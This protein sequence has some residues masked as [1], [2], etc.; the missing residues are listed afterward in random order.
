MAWG[1]RLA[2]AC[3]STEVGFWAF[4]QS[5]CKG[6]APPH[7]LLQWKK[8]FKRNDARPPNLHGTV[9]MPNDYPRVRAAREGSVVDLI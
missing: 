7:V 3:N 5:S 1:W 6:V 9:V 4:N 2:L 8:I